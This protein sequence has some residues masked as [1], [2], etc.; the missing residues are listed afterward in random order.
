[1]KTIVFLASLSGLLALHASTVG[2]EV[3]GDAAGPADAQDAGDASAINPADITN[4]NCN[5]SVVFQE[6][7]NPPA[8]CT[9]GSTYDAG[10]VGIFRTCTYLNSGTLF[11][12]SES[13]TESFF[14][15]A[16]PTANG[17]V[18]GGFVQQVN[19]NVQSNCPF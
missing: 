4:I 19:S 1:M 16:V 12:C 3:T 10:D 17:C 13:F 15:S 18:D 9:F 6:F 11:I 8:T 5:D 14:H 7:N 2:A